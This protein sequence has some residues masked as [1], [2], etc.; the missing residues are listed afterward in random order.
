MLRQERTK[1]LEV[2]RIV[3]RLGGLDLHA[4]GDRGAE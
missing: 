3:M 1:M 2:L 4:L